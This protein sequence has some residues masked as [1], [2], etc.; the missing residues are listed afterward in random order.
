VEKY[1]R[2]GHV[3]DDSI[4]RRMRILCW[5]SKATDTHSEHVI[6]IAFPLQQWLP[7]WYMTRTLSVL[8]CI[9]KVLTEYRIF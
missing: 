4:Q 6:F 1:G 3:T 2:A 9:V 5:I 7:Q 8:L